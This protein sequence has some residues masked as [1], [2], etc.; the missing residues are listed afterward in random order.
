M[1]NL[2][3][4]K[5]QKPAKRN[6]IRPLRAG[7]IA[8]V[9]CAILLGTVGAASPGLREMLS[10]ALGGFAPYAQEQEDKIYHINGME[11][12]VLSVLADDFTIRAYVEARDPEG[13]IF[14]KID[15]LTI[16]TRVNGGVDVPTV[17]EWLAPNATESWMSGMEC[18]GF[19]EESG[20]ALLVAS[21]WKMM[22][23]GLT[24]AAVEIRAMNSY[25]TGEYEEVWRNKRSLTIPVDVKPVE[26]TVLGADT[27]L[28]SGL[29]A[30]E[31]RLSPLG[32][33]LIFRDYETH[34]EALEG[35]EGARVSAKLADGSI[36]EA[37]Q[38]GACGLFLEPYDENSY[39]IMTWNFREPVEAD[40]IEGIY[41]GEDY[42][43]M[44]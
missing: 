29:D 31:A 28:A 34:R 14:N 1:N 11:F 2:M 21:A 5:E 37:A 18:L 35:S 3:E 27:V 4:Q 13:N 43:P 17:N 38:G 15:D 10:A 39:R 22:P 25:L 36:V 6:G 30:E 41:V 9:L 12:K 42:F 16:P 44:Q 24:N 40:Q 20:T 32:L 26:S 23:E 8:A 19:D 33:T 7:L